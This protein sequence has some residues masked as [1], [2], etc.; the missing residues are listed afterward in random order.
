MT[1]GPGPLLTGGVAKRQRKSATADAP[2]D[3]ALMGVVV[4]DQCGERFAIQHSLF[5]QDALLAA[6][7]ATWLAEKFVW[8]HIQER[9]HAQTI[10]LPA[11]TAMT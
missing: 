7:Q 1:R 5:T 4:C 11:A 10:E 6:R 9:H 8:D 3:K 2:E